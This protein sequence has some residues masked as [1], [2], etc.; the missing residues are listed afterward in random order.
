[1]A[2]RD[3]RTLSKNLTFSVGGRLMC[4][5]AKGPGLAMRN[6]K[7]ELLHFLDGSMKVRWK[8][9][10]MRYT[11]CKTNH[12]PVDAE[13]EKTLDARVDAIVAQAAIAA[14]ETGHSHVAE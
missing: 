2:R 3:E 13:S 9:R 10:D 6:T 11:H 12:A 5:D 1:M 14:K 4:V 7:V 8:G